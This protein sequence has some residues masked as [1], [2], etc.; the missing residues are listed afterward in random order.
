M[1]ACC[2]PSSSSRLSTPRRTV[3][4]SV[5]SAACSRS[6]SMRERAVGMDTMTNSLVSSSCSR[7]SSSR[8]CSW[9]SLRDP[10][11]DG[12]VASA[13]P[14]PARPFARSLAPPL[15][16]L[17]SR[18]VAM[19]TAAVAV[20]NLARRASSRSMNR[21]RNCGKLSSRSVWPVGAVSMITRSKRTPSSLRRARR[22]TLANATS[23]STPGGT[24]SSTFAKSAIP[25][26]PPGPALCP[27][28]SPVSSALNSRTASSTCTSTAQSEP[29]ATP[30]TRRGFPSD[31][32]TSSASPSE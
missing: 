25:I 6:D 32:S 12:S 22:T 5:L 13:A 29:P 8:I 28:A 14:P 31:R 18:L 11:A 27:S 3:T 21:S 26:W 30:S 9:K 1:K 16:R 17:P 7:A 10:T 4:P 23:S 15:N 24:A 2:W 20:S 19:P